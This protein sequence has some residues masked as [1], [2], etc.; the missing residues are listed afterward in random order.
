MDKQNNR[1]VF[2]K[3]I[4]APQVLCIDQEGTN[5]GIIPTYQALNLAKSAG[6][7]LVMV[8]TGKDNVPTCKILDL[9]KFK[10]D[11]SKR[12]KESAKKQ[13]EAAHKLKEIKIRPSTEANDLKIKADKVSEFLE[14]GHKVKISVRFRGREMAHKEVGQETL[15]MLLSYVAGAQIID[16]PKM[17]GRDLSITL[18]KAKEKIAS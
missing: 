18:V 3:Y 4:R 6:L 11:Q 10:Y 7:E 12:Q 2:G 8:A 16:A 13:R 15:D 9:G 5:L 17:E 14:E 1:I